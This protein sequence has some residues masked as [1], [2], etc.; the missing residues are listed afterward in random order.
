[1]RNNVRKYL[2]AKGSLIAIVFFYAKEIGKEEN[3]FY[4]TLSYCMYIWYMD[5]QIWYRKE[6]KRSEYVAVARN[7]EGSLGIKLA[8]K[9][10]IWVRDWKNVDKTVPFLRPSFEKEKK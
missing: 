4:C 8:H 3:V 5:H 9:K 7:I 10:I 2:K 6:I 1:M